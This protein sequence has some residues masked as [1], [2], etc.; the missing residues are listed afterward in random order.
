[1]KS[2]PTAPCR[3][4]VGSVNTAGEILASRQSIPPKRVFVTVS[5]TIR[6]K[7]F[8]GQL[9]VQQYCHYS[10]QMT[11]APTMP[12]DGEYRGVSREVSDSGNNQR[13]CHPLSSTP[14]RD[15]TII[16]GVIAATGK[17]WW[18]GAVSPEGIVVMRNPKFSRVDGQIDTQGT[19][20]AQYRG[21]LPPDLVAQLDGGGTNCI[22]KFVWQRE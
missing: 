13:R 17:K 22:V 5:G 10:V 3:L 20:R 4:N 15:L 6:D 16:N 14:P 1:M 12:F 9:L 2:A 19:I 11:L 18:E 8:T 7:V 21:E